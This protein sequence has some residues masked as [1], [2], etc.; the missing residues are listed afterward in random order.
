MAVTRDFIHRIESAQ[1][2]EYYFVHLL[3][4]HDPFVLDQDCNLR[5]WRV[6]DVAPGPNIVAERDE[7]YRFYFKQ[8]QCAQKELLAIVDA[9]DR[10]PLLRDATIFVHGDH[11]LADKRPKCRGLAGS[12]TSERRVRTGLARRLHRR[13]NT[14]LA[15]R[16][17]YEAVGIARDL[18][19]VG[20]VR[21]QT[22]GPA[23]VATQRPDAATE[24]QLAAAARHRAI[25]ARATPKCSLQIGQ[26]SGQGYECTLATQC[27]DPRET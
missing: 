13:Q 6:P 10:N 22:V 18:P 21:F 4:P 23:G 27:A 9:V 15:G 17:I 24:K 8:V 16:P 14:G 7:A 19:D 25:L 2:G 3:L 11:G 26:W 20:G 5:Y 12:R 1:R